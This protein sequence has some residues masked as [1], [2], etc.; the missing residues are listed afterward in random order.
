MH[1]EQTR[2]RAYNIKAKDKACPVCRG[3]R[4]Q[5]TDGAPCAGCGRM[6][7]TKV[8]PGCAGLPERVE[9]KTCIGCGTAAGKNPE[10]RFEPQRRSSSGWGNIF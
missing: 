3:L 9:G 6:R 7:D 8:C 5:I 4:Y 2:K 10:Y 1:N